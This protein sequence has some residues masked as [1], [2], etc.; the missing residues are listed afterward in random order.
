[1]HFHYPLSN[2]FP[3]LV[4]L[5]LPLP[6]RNHRF[7][8]LLSKAV[9]KSTNSSFEGAVHSLCTRL[10]LPAWYWALSESV[11]IDA[12]SHVCMTGKREW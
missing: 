8:F 10:A 5:P 9:S 6:L 3:P 1:M 11:V 7:L 4:P 2:V 12:V